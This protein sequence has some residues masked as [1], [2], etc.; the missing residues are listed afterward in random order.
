MFALIS[1]CIKFLMQFDIKDGQYNHKMILTVKNCCRKQFIMQH[2]GRAVGGGGGGGG[3]A[4]SIEVY[5]H[6]FL[7]VTPCIVLKCM[8]HC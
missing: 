8:L 5:F 3:G 6:M 1:L 2:A 7:Q 4:C